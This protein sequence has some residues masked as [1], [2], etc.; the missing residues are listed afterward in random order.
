MVSYI[1]ICIHIHIHMYIHIY[2]DVYTHLYMYICLYLSDSI[3]VFLQ[4]TITIYGIHERT[5]TVSFTARAVAPPTLGAG[6]TRLSIY[7]SKSPCSAVS[8]VNGNESNLQWLPRCLSKPRRGYL[9]SRANCRSGSR[10][11]PELLIA[12]A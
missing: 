9:Q 8:E 11:L 4:I 12:R 2:I 3:Y 6:E 10:Y 5:R 1:Y 7:L